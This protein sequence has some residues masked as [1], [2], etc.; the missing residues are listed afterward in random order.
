MHVFQPIPVENLELN[1][2]ETIG[3]DWALVPKQRVKKCWS[4]LS[5][6]NSGRK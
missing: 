3:K 6:V 1:P 5:L 2:F 4:K